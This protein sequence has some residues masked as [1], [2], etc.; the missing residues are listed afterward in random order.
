MTR[1][2]RRVAAIDVGSNSIRLVVADVAPPASITVVDELRLTPRLGAGLHETGLLGAEPMRHAL[3]A[4]RRMVA[5]AGTLHAHRTVAVATSAVRDA[6]NG[7][8]F[9]RRVEE[10]TGLRL[11]VLDGEEEAR[12]A[13]RSARAYLPL[14]GGRAVVLDI[15]GGSLE[16]ALGLDGALVHPHSFPLGAIR[17]TERFLARGAGRPALHRLRAAVRAELAGAIDVAAWRD[18]TLVGS[19]G[20]CTTLATVVLAR[21]GTPAKRGTHGEHATHVP[22]PE[23]EAV[24]EWLRAMGPARRREVPGLKPERADIIVAGLAAA[25]EV[26]AFLDA[27]DV[28]VSAYGIREGLLLATLDEGETAADE[29]AR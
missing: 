6:A 18:A 11:R 29:I 7:A 23:L 12:L 19:G 14:D 21:R 26:A 2:A 27:P 9:L 13:F 25:A 20:T 4:L 5:L 15:G 8:A 24:L 16:L 3:D 10:E 17:L 1:A 28:T 22:R